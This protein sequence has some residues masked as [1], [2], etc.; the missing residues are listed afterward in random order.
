MWIWQ[1]W[2]AKAWAKSSDKV[3]ASGLDFRVNLPADGIVVRADGKLL[4]RVVENLLSN[5][6]KYAM[7]ASRV[8]LD[9]TE[10]AGHGV[11]TVKNISAI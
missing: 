5:V 6:F 3:E 2:S 8:Y 7:P 11:F 9:V 1:I 4:W 10:H